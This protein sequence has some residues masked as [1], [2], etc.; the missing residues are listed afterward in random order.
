[1]SGAAGAVLIAG[2]GHI[3]RDRGVAWHLE[4]RGAKTEAIVSIALIEVE[5]GKTDAEAFLPK[6]PAGKPA[7]DFVWFTPR[8]ARPDPCE[9]LRRQFEKKG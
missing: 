6:D 1:V 5:E 9:Q 2:N 7:V 4:R 3:R 8:P